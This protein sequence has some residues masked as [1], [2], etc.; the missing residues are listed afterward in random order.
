VNTTSKKQLF[1]IFVLVTF[2]GS[3]AAVAIMDAFV[4]TQ[5]KQQLIYDGPLLNSEEA[6]FHQKNY[7]VIKLFTSIDCNTCEEATSTAAR[8]LHLAAFVLLHLLVLNWYVAARSDVF[9]EYRY[10]STWRVV[11]AI[12]SR[13]GSAR[14]ALGDGVTLLHDVAGG[15]HGH[16]VTMIWL[17]W[18]AGAG[19]NAQDESGTTPLLLAVSADQ[20][21]VV[22]S[23]LSVG[24]EINARDA[25]GKTALD[26]ADEV[27][28]RDASGKSALDRAF[29]RKIWE[30]LRQAGGK[31]GAELDAET[32]KPEPEPAPPEPGR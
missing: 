15:E 29:D 23:L 2:L 3:S 11:H 7:V 10:G 20:A 21:D 16:A 22:K 6:P 31:T 8:R 25:N 32:A 24:A 14:Q 1:A 13:P 18:A 17:L 28:A 12:F 26:M 27:S 5:S 19:V 30:V 4:P 9:T